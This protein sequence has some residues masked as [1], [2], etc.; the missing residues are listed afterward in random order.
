VGGDDGLQVVLSEYTTPGLSADVIKTQTGF[1][2]N[3]IC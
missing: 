1:G 2:F 3:K